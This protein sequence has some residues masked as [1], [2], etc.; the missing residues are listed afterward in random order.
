[1]GKVKPPKAVFDSWTPK[2]Q[3]AYNAE[4]GSMEAERDAHLS[5]AAQY[6]ANAADADQRKWAYQASIDGNAGKHDPSNKVGGELGSQFMVHKSNSEAEDARTAAE[7]EKMK[8]KGIDQTI[9]GLKVEGE[10]AGSMTKQQYINETVKQRDADYAKLY[11]IQAKQADLQKELDDTWFFGKDDLRQQI[12]DCQAQIDALQSDI[13]FNQ[14][15]LDNTEPLAPT[16]PSP[17]IPP[18]QTFVHTGAKLACSFA[19]PMGPAALVAD[20]SRMTME[21]GPQMANI[22]DIKPLT[23]IPCMGLCNTMSNPAVAAATAAKLG[24][25][26]PVPCVP[27]IPAPW[28]P[29]KSNVLVNGIPALLN[30]DTLQCAWGGV[31]TILPG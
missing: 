10:D 27:V 18:G 28:K 2:Q 3:G 1:M 19:I 11:E 29:G 23:N 20:P 21:G 30:T 12:A 24:V 25:F 8:A 16:P 9:K 26:T 13:D 7:Q 31:I 4:I 14:N 15:N 5:N 6:D 22:S 17:P